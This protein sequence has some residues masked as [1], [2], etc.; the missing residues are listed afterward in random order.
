[1]GLE[2]GTEPEL[3]ADRA[4]AAMEIIFGAY[5]PSRR[6]ERAELPPPIDGNPLVEMVEDG[7]LS[8]EL[9]NEGDE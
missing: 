2:T 7:A 4:P 9:A 8:P 1:M 3:S 5:D 6:R